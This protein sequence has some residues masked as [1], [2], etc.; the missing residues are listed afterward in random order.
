[1]R[2]LTFIRS[3]L[4]AT[5]HARRLRH[6]RGRALDKVCVAGWRLTATHLPR[7]TSAGR[8]LRHYRIVHPRSAITSP[9]EAEQF[10]PAIC[11]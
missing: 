3:T 9:E 1:M 4:P 6:F 10:V 5:P 11:G 7:T 8:H 2:Y